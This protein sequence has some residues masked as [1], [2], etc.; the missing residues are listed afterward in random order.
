MA[1]SSVF[2]PDSFHVSPTEGSVSSLWAGKNPNERGTASA[3]KMP[4][5]T[6]WISR[7]L[8]QPSTMTGKG[9]GGKLLEMVKE[10][11]AKM[12]GGTVIVCPGGYGSDPETQ[13]NFYR[14]HGFEGDEKM[15][16]E[17]VPQVVT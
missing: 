17:I 16:L 12:G 3:N 4:D 10:E 2:E 6:W 13:K 15:E 14:K 7:V 11:I 1:Y 8:V 5:G 9:I